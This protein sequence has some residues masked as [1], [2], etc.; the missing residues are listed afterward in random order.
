MAY[1]PMRGRRDHVKVSWDYVIISYPLQGLSIILI[2]P[3][4]LPPECMIKQEQV[5]K[6]QPALKDRRIYLG[7]NFHMKFDIFT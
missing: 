2:T 6:S 1:Y 4:S 5:P 7:P 3:M